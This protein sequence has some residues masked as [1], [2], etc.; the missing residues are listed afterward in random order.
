MEVGICRK[1]IK[2]Q[3]FLNRSQEPFHFAGMKERMNLIQYVEKEGENRGRE[4]SFTLRNCEHR[5]KI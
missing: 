2:R 5:T 1:M 4:V 3:P